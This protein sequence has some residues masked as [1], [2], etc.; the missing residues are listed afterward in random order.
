MLARHLEG[1]GLSTVGISLVR[2]HT[3]KVRPPRYLFVPFPFGRALGK[4]NDPSFQFD[5]INAALALFG[6]PESEKPILEDFPVILD[7][8]PENNEILACALVAPPRKVGKQS[9]PV[10]AEEIEAEIKSLRPFYNE[11][12]EKLGRTMVGI[13]R[14][15]P[16][17]IE[18]A[19]LYLS[20]FARGQ[21]VTPPECPPGIRLIQYLRWCADDLKTFYLEA[22][23]T[24][25]GDQSWTN[26]QLQDW[27][28]KDTA[29]GALILAVQ[30]RM[31]EIG[32]ALDKAI[33]IGL[34]PRGYS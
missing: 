30:R 21:E 29:L 11:S 32:E 19:A 8:E 1:A 24:K 5:V 3:E 28:W 27:L 26:Q 9:A 12:Q 31:N 18:K 23:V 16:E 2:L 4:P 15:S 17:V 10:E 13:S 34:V 7:E 14:I 25:Q 6:R 20:T 33:S 22:A